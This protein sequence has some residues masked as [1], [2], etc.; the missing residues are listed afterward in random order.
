MLELMILTRSQ[1]SENG[2]CRHGKVRYLIVIFFD[3]L[4]STL[5]RG[6]AVNS[7]CISCKYQNII[8]ADF[9][10]VIKGSDQMNYAKPRS[11]KSS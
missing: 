11:I 6:V 7:F 8:G 1:Q 10:V 5:L 4:V 3:W 2:R 9:G